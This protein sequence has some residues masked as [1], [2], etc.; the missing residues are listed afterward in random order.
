MHGIH[1]T[2]AQEMEQIDTK[3]IVEEV[4][5]IYLVYLQKKYYQQMHD[6]TIWHIQD[7]YVDS[8]FANCNNM[9][10]LDVNLVIEHDFEG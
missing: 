5:V 9:H 6:R 1:R 7:S 10:I 3:L 4:I 2:L 8:G